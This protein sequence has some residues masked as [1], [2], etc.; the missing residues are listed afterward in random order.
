GSFFAEPCA[1]SPMGQ[2]AAAYKLARPHRHRDTG[3]QS[4]LALDGSIQGVYATHSSFNL[5]QDGLHWSDNFSPTRQ[6]QVL[7]GSHGVG[8]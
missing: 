3:L 5:N 8:F 4:Q 6:C 2:F 1:Y 7:S